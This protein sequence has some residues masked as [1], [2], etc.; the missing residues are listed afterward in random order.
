[1]LRTKITAIL[2]AAVLA[3]S[4]L[5]LTACM[6]NVEEESSNASTSSN[7]TSGGIGETVSEV[8]SD[9]ADGMT[10]TEEVSKE[11][12]ENGHV[13]DTVQSETSNNESGT[14]KNTAAPYYT[15]K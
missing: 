5:S 7:G 11:N 2:L 1:M 3:V 15:G 6:K 14:R 4:A 10:G 9:I 8:I 12:A 13:T